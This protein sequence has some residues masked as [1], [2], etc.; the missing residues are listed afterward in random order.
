MMVN[1]KTA[2]AMLAAWREGL[3]LGAALQLFSARLDQSKLA[4]KIEEQRQLS[5]IGK[6]NFARAGASDVAP[7]ID[8]IA[9]GMSH[10]SATVEARESQV[11]QLI[12]GLERG[13]WLAVGCPADRPK[14]MEPEPVPQFL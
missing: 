14:A 12:E 6:R 11:R 4:G 13:E 3:E 7:L 1:R 9:A 10:L 2:D 8:T 5:E